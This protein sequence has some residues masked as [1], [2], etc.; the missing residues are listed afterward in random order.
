M[1]DIDPIEAGPPDKGEVI[2][3]LTLKFKSGSVDIVLAGLIPALDPTRAEEGNHRFEVYRVPA[4]ADTLVIFER[5][6]SKAALEEHWQLDYTKKAIDLFAE[7]LAEPIVNGKNV[8]YL[9]DVR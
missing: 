3:V 4:C 5:W 1:A 9:T 7:H 6:S 2:V 8:L